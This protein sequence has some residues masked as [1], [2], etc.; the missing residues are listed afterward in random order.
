[1]SHSAKVPEREGSKLER[2]LAAANNLYMYD[3]DDELIVL[4]L[5]LN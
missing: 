3:K 2:S 5:Y 4:T 1:M